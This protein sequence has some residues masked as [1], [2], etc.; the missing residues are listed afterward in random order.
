MDNRNMKPILEDVY[1]DNGEISH[2]HL[3]D[4]RAGEILWSSDPEE[5]IARGGRIHRSPVDVEKLKDAFEAGKDYGRE[6]GLFD[7]GHLSSSYCV[8][9][10][11]DQW[12]RKNS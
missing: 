8:A 10:D 11:F 12:I 3:I 2:Y 1:A 6:G 4:P 9:D 5:T 7:F